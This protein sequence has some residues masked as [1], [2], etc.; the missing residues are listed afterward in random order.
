MSDRTMVLC[1]GGSRDGLWVEYRGAT[2]TWSTPVARKI[3]TGWPWPS[4]VSVVETPALEV[5]RLAQMMMQRSDGRVEAFDFYLIDGLHRDH[6]FAIL[7]Q[8]YRKE[9]G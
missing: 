5:Y 1:V 7:T 2:M 4:E 8:G 9:R 3:E 6:V